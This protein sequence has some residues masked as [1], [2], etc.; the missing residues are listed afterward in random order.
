MKRR[1]LGRTTAFDAAAQL[2]HETSL[3]ESWRC[4]NKTE[5]SVLIPAVMHAEGRR[6][7]SKSGQFDAR[8]ALARISNSAE[9][10]S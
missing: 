7:A 4:G 10:L 2:A 5:P 6:W 1:F 3:G 9:T 8:H